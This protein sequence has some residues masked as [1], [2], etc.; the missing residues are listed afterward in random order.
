MADGFVKTAFLS[1]KRET[2]GFGLDASC[3][4]PLDVGVG[5]DSI[6]FL[7]DAY[8]TMYCLLEVFLTRCPRYSCFSVDER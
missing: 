5:I 7:C 1:R 3:M 6:C 8:D 2:G 4:A